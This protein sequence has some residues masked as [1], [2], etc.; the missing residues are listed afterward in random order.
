MSIEIGEHIENLIKTHW[1]L[2]GNIVGTHW[3]PGKNEKKKIPL[4][5]PDKLKRKKRMKALRVP[6]MGVFFLSTSTQ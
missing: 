5:L 6:I 2:K 4:P 3:E 1:E